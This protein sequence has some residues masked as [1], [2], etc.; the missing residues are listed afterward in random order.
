MF[1]VKIKNNTAI[2]TN[3]TILYM[4]VCV[5]VWANSYGNILVCINT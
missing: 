3:T 5:C 4:C 2:P 1:T